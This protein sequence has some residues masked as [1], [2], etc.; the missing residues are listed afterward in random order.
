MKK[1]VSFF[2]V[3]ALIVKTGHDF[4]TIKAVNMVKVD[5]GEHLCLITSTNLFFILL[6]AR[7]LVETRRGQTRKSEQRRETGGGEQGGV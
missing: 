3:Q 6:P 1:M 4:S 7:P 5:T 2:K